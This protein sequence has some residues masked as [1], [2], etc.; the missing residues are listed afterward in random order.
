MRCFQMEHPEM[1]PISKRT[2]LENLN[3][4]NI[5]KELFSIDTL[6]LSECY[7]RGINKAQVLIEESML[8]LVG[9]MHEKINKK[10]LCKCDIYVHAQ[11]NIHFPVFFDFS[12]NIYTS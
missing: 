9:D 7:A 3:W 12:Q 5:D 10:G 1:K 4:Q 8:S 11:V 2:G 6:N